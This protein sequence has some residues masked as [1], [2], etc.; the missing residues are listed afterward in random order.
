[1]A[2][3]VVTVTVAVPDLVPSSVDV[4]VTVAVPA[5]IGVKTPVL[6]TDPIVVGLTDQFTEL[7]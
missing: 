6:L 1:M 7:V 3:G 5:V 2:A 4:A